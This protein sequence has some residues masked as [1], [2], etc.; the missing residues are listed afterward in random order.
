MQMK[1]FTCGNFPRRKL[2][3]MR[4]NCS[5]RNS[6]SWKR[7][8]EASTIPEEITVSSTCHTFFATLGQK[9]SKNKN[10]YHFTSTIIKFEFAANNKE[11]FP[12]F[13]VQMSESLRPSV[14]CRLKFHV[15][16]FSSG[17]L[18]GVASGDCPAKTH[19]LLLDPNLPS[20]HTFGRPFLGRLLAQSWSHVRQSRIR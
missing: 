10:I 15:I 18:L 19:G 5:S 11:S 7:R 17:H 12:D 2:S 20:L 16:S 6:T 4:E 1:S 13:S 8:S 9:M 14:H 3:I